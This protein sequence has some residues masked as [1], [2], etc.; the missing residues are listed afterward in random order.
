MF[1]VLALLI[2]ALALFILSPGLIPGLV[3]RGLM[4]GQVILGRMCGL[5][6]PGTISR[7]V[8]VYLSDPIV[9]SS[10]FVFRGTPHTSLSTPWGGAKALSLRLCNAKHVSRSQRDLCARA[11]LT[12]QDE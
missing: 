12:R 6:T 3:T 10:V 7:R 8:V 5:A 9:T 2:L 11:T 1:L 4:L